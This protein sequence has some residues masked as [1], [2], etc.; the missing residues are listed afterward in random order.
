MDNVLNTLQVCNHNLFRLEPFCL[1]LLL[2]LE[3]FE[4]LLLLDFAEVA[5]DLLLLDDAFK[6]LLSLDSLLSLLP[7][8]VAY[9]F[10]NINARLE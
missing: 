9:S 2:D 5:F 7:F 6:Q 3:L 10:V 1:L 8:G 4:T